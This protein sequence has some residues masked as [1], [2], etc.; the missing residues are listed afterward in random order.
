MP[1]I[2][3]PPIG[4]SLAP[5]SILHKDVSV[6]SPSLRWERMASSG[7]DRVFIIPVVR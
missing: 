3:S 6:F 5:G 4:E 7:W 1:V 2:R